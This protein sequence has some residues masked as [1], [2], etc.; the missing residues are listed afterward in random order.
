MSLRCQGLLSNGKKCTEIQLGLI[1]FDVCLEVRDQGAKHALRIAAA[2]DL[3]GC[4][5]M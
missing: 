5:A 1:S 2:L 4:L 3:S